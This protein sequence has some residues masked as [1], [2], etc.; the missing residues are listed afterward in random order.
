VGGTHIFKGV[1]I[2]KLEPVFFTVTHHVGHWS[3]LVVLLTYRTMASPGPA[4]VVLQMSHQRYRLPCAVSPF[5]Q[6]VLPAS[7]HSK[8]PTTVTSL[9]QLYLPC[10]AMPIA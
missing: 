7:P 5:A 9:F 1:A 6:P 8:P 3:D 2:L 4:N 10:A